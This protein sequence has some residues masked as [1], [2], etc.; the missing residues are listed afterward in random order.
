M[1]LLDFDT[2]VLADR[3]LDLAN[4]DVHVDLRVM[5][6]LLSEDMAYVARVAIAEAARAVGADAHRMEVYREA[7]RARLVCVYTFRPQWIPVA[8]RLLDQLG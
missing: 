6:G 4:L 7:T 2:A 8:E 3:E 5:Q 1:G